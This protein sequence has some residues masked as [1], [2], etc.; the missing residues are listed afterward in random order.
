MQPKKGNFKLFVDIEISILVDIAF[1]LTNTLIS[2]SID[3]HRYF[4]LNKIEIQ[5]FLHS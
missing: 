5:H 2:I 1:V 4:D 3:R